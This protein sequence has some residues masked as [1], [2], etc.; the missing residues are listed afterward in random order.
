MSTYY[1]EYPPHC[2]K[3]GIFLNGSDSEDRQACLK[4]P[5]RNYRGNATTTLAPP[6]VPYPLHTG[7]IPDSSSSLYTV[8]CRPWPRDSY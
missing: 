2:E 1:V 8:G 6:D 4:N 5:K 3:T 7:E